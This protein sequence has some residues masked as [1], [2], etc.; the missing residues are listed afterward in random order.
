MDNWI[1]GT[2]LFIV[3]YCVLKY[4]SG[5]MT[6]GAE[7]LL[8]ILLYVC[9][10]ML[11]YIVKS[12]SLK[13]CFLIL[14]LI[15]LLAS[16]YYVNILFLLPAPM[17]GAE[18]MGRFSENVKLSVVPAALI[19]VFV[20]RSFFPE[21]MLAAVFS[22]C[23]FILSR[24]AYSRV[25]ML[26]GE[27]DRLRERNDALYK[28]LD[29]STDYENQLRYLTQMEERNS[30]AQKIHDKVGH[31]IAGS[32]IQL[33]AASVII[34]SDTAKARDII[35]NVI[36]VLKEGMENIR[37]TLRNI[38]PAAEQLGINRLKAVLDKFTRNSSIKAFL[39][40][41]GDLSPVSHLQWKIVMD[42]LKE[43]LTNTLKYSSATTVK[44]DLAVLNK[45]IRVEVRDNGVGAFSPNKGLGLRGMEERTES[46]GGKLIIDGSKG[47]SI[48]MLLP[49]SE[50]S[51]EDKSADSR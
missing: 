2:K 47:F 1:I 27:V 31:S 30:L 35:G 46:A 26:S 38:K 43:A 18:L 23:M 28:R 34:G 7:V 49:V 41:N 22:L 24:K 45:L 33:E 39:S 3:L 19:V 10:N 13:R 4:V 44:V 5:N 40:Y 42:N 48:I 20:S 9:I 29:V 8:L 15:L 14:S 21:Y 36:Q 12:E 16:A 6:R 32:L 51:D 25:S 50:V 17:N 37:S 11:F